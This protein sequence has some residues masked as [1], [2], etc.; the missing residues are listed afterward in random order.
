MPK[1]PLPD[2]VAQ[3]LA[4]PNPSVITSLRPDGSPV[5]VA[6]WYLWEDGRVLVN[7]DDARTRVRYLRQDPRT[8]I[9][10]L[11]EDDW[12]THVS[13]QGRVVEWAPDEGLADIDRISAA[14]HRQPLPGTGPLPG[15]RLDRGRPV[16]RLG[17]SEGQRQPGE[18]TGLTTTAEAVAARRDRRPVPRPGPSTARRAASAG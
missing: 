18:L 5:S 8:T 11:A 13:M 3:L 12:Y 14:L 17:E 9:T 7:M 15:Q 1:P 2:E 4:R 16:A 6:T 10:V